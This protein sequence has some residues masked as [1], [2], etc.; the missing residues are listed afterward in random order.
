LPECIYLSVPTLSE[1]ATYLFDSTLRA[2]GVFTWKQVLHLKTGKPMRDA[3]REVLDER[4]EA[5]VVRALSNADAPTTYVDI[6]ALEQAPTVNGS[7]KVLSPFD[8]VVIHRDRLSTL[9]GFDYRIECYISAPKR[10]FGYFC[11]PILYGDKFVGRIDCKAHRADQRFEV[12]SLN[13]EDGKL[14]R[15]QFFPALSDEL[16]RLADFN[17]CPLLDASVVAK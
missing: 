12:L 13:L 3:M 10:V 14:D 5:G 7:L 2:H 11:L 16:Q 17:K 8:N 15:D 9:F 4:I 1:Y 6:N